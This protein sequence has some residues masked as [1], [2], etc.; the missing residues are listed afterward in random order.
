MTKTQIKIV[1]ELKNYK[2]Q[3]YREIKTFELKENK[4]FV[5]VFL[6]IG[7]KDDV[8]KLT[9]IFCRDT[10]VIFIGKRGK[11]RIKRTSNNEKEYNTLSIIY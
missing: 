6:T 10:Y 8:G 4:Y 1:N 2:L 5:C 11:I 7:C 9:S 3:D